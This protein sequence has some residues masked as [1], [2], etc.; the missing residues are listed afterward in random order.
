MVILSK[1]TKV[2][3]GLTLKMGSIL[4]TKMEYATPICISFSVVRP[5]VFSSLTIPLRTFGTLVIFFLHPLP[6]V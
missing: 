1:T 5:T 3:S 2:I 4:S 6:D